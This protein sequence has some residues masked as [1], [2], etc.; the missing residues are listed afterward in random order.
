MSLSE[1]AVVAEYRRLARDSKERFDVLRHVPQLGQQHWRYYFSSAF[2]SFTALW[3]LVKRHRALLI[4]QCD[5]QRMDVG[6]VASRIGQLYFHFYLRTSRMQYLKQSMTFFDALRSRQYY[7]SQNDMDAAV[8]GGKQFRFL[9]RYIVVAILLQLP[10]NFILSLIR[11]LT[12]AG[13]GGPA[14]AQ[15]A[16]NFLQVIV[17]PYEEWSQAPLRY[18][19]ASL[20]PR[21]QQ[22]IRLRHAL[23][24]SSVSDQVCNCQ[25]YQGCHS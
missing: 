12:E 8:L 2:D 17:G 15:E 21:E 16:T 19:A 22:G 3:K 18:Q 24:V 9:A 23:L 25:V 10:K 20:R 5:L 14:V 4:E 1:E 7:L 11:E 13:K 6:D